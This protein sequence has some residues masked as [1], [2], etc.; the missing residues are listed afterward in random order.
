M[1]RA[2]D[3][4][5]KID[6]LDRRLKLVEDAL[7]EVVQTRVHHVDLHSDLDKHRNLDKHESD[8][9]N[10]VVEGVDV[11]PEEEFTPPAGTR[12]KRTRKKT[13]VVD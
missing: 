13:A 9:R 2:I 1:G 7:E 10:A 12:K 11:E 3:M 8:L 4:E 5:N 6:A